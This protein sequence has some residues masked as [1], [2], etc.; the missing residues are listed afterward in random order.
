MMKKETKIICLVLALAVAFSLSACKD[1]ENTLPKPDGQSSN[2]DEQPEN[3]IEEI[4][5]GGEEN[6]PVTPSELNVFEGNIEFVLSNGG[7]T[8]KASSSVSG[9]LISKTNDF[10]EVI[11]DKDKKNLTFAQIKF[12]P[13]TNTEKLAPSF[14]DDNVTALRNLEFPGSVQIGK[15]GVYA[16]VVI[17]SSDTQTVEA[18]LVDIEGGVI[19]ITLSANN[20][21]K[22]DEFPGLKQ[23]VETFEIV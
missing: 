14:I 11:N 6:T 4:S 2:N 23:I 18:Y 12:F 9:Y 5:E 22:A 7:G 13:D 1:K 3:G 20:E 16:E 8:V 10:C 19:A 17:G 15:D 21:L